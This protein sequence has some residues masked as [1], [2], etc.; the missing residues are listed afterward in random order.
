MKTIIAATDFSDIACNA[1]YYAAHLSA[2]VGAKLLLYHAVETNAIVAEST[3]INLGEYY[4]D[5]ALIKLK[6][7]KT[8]LIAFTDNS[9]PIEVKLRW[10]KADAE[11]AQLCYEEKPFVLVM[12]ATRKNSLDRFLTGSRTVNVSRQCEAPLLLIPENVSFKKIKTIAIATDFK[13]VVDS[14]PLQELTHWMKNFAAGIEIVNVMP[15]SGA[16]GED[17]AEAVAMETHFHEFNPQFRYVT[18]NNPLVGLHEYE[19][20]Y[21]PD[22]LI[23][24]PKTHSLFHKSLCKQLI[25]HPSVPLLVMRKH[26]HSYNPE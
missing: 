13:K 17:V 15:A 26:L 19:E 3:M 6:Q 22:L 1:V 24:I 10:G 11:M 16:K 2:S 4:A 25:L 18:S 12:A 14:M 21:Q 9:I 5:E 23:V 8:E 20:K 7:L